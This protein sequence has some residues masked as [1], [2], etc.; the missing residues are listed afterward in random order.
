MYFYVV[1]CIY[2]YVDY[3]AATN[4]WHQATWLICEHMYNALYSQTSL[5]PVSA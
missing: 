1:Q 4:M 2:I 5:S 3:P